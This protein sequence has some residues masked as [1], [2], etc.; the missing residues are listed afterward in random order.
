[1]AQIVWTEPA[2]IDLDEIGEYIAFDKPS[3]AKKLVATV[4][5]SVK[6]LKHFPKSGKCP[7]ELKNT[8]YLEIIVGP[9]R[10]FYRIDNDKVFIL[11]VMRSERELKLFILDS[12]SNTS[13]YWDRNA[14]H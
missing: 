10:I 13:S 14:H 2:L 8:D 1:M 5:K 9:C 12:R 4:F 7:P 11:Y 6:R 3:V